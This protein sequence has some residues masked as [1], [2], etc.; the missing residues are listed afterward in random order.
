MAFTLSNKVQDATLQYLMPKLVEGALQGNVGAALFL[1]KGRAEEWKGSQVL[2]P[3]KWQVN[4][5]ASSF[6]GFQTL[7]TTQVDN[8]FNLT[9]NV[10]FNQ[11]PVTLAKTDLSLNDTE[12]QVA[13]LM[14]RQISS[15]NLDLGQFI[16]QS[17]YGDGTG[18]GGLNILGLAAGIDDG[19]LVPT[20]GGQSRSMYPALDA[21]VFASGGAL[22]LALL[23]QSR[24]A[25][26]Q[27][28]QRP[29]I[30]V[31]TKTIRSL[32]SQLLDPI[33]RFN[34]PVDGR[35][36]VY[37][38]MAQKNL[39]FDDAPVVADSLAPSGQWWM[40]NEDSMFFAYLPRYTDSQPIKFVA[41]A[42][43]GEPNPEVANEYGFHWTG[44]VRSQNQEVLVGRVILAGNMVYKNPRYN[45]RIDGI[46]HI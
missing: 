38:N 30:N 42:L 18:N 6:L 10:S 24:D 9:Y 43:T 27:G 12:Q 23:Y 34:V 1:T 32:Y 3:F 11:I 45:S 5:N 16:G 36:D 21:N 4:P 28:H 41:G 44:F 7:P 35:D 2:V 15:D 8:T 39:M 37:L 29:T 14:E 17:F 46:T 20:I 26:L 31:T 13:N 19:T 33:V 25:S 40:I 22:T